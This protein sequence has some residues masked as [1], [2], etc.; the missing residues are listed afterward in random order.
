M[1]LLFL[2]LFVFATI[3]VEL[4]GRVATRDAVPLSSLHEFA[5]FWDAGRM[6]P[7]I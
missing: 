3:I 5:N 2:T 4:F 6:M 7:A 1:A